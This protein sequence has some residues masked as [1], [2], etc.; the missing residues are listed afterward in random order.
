MPARSSST[1]PA[2]RDWDAIGELKQAVDGIPVL[3][4]GDIWEA[5]DAVAMV[6]RTG[7]DGV[8]IGRGCLGRPWLFGDLVR[9][10]HGRAAVAHGSS[11]S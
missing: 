4:N 3:G 6:R 5:A 9:A 2:R 8:V 11:G 10:F 7:C 1:T